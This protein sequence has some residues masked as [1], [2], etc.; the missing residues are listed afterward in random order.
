MLMFKCNAFPLLDSY[1][2]ARAHFENV[3]PM[4]SGDYK[5]VKPIHLRSRPTE[6]IMRDGDDVVYISIYGTNHSESEMRGM[7]DT[8]TTMRWKPN[9]EIHLRPFLYN[10]IYEQLYS[11][12]GLNFYRYDNAL[13]VQTYQTFRLRNDNWGEVATA[14]NTNIF[15][16][17]TTGYLQ[18]MNPERR[19]RLL[20]NRKRANNVRSHYKE[21][22][23]YLRMMLKLREGVFS[24]QEAADTLGLKDGAQEPRWHTLAGSN[25]IQVKNQHNYYYHS[26]RKGADLPEFMAL[27][28]S[29]DP[30]KFYRA[31]LM[32][33]RA[34]GKR[35]YQTGRVATLTESVAIKAL[36]EMLF[37]VHRDEVFDE[38]VLEAFDT[39]K[40]IHKWV[41]D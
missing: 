39:A 38:Q 10:C 32:M 22:R 33:V 9:G 3:K 19:T 29:G 34:Y 24:L 7:L 37:Y 13:W 16:R 12:L 18:L 4:M 6:R 17:D 26:D 40:D 1:E 41:R 36:D 28:G 21:F 14:D 8:Q 27:I 30:E 11:L 31:S 35:E 5:G 23:D 20:V 2:K 25:L 15:K